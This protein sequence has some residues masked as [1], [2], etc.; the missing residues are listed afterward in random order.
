MVWLEGGPPGKIR[1]SGPLRELWR[2]L[3]RCGLGFAGWLRAGFQP[4]FERDQDV[5]A[6]LDGLR[7]LVIFGLPAQSAS[8]G[9][10]GALEALQLSRSV[11][12]LLESLGSQF[13]PLFS[14]RPPAFVVAGVADEAGS[15][16]QR[17]SLPYAL[18]KQL[19]SRAARH[20]EHRDDLAAAPAD[21]GDGAI[22]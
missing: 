17:L 2:S 5:D 1:A 14:R 18:G 16:Y 13:Q 4:P 15:L 11:V 9:G 22:A 7:V 10:C 6:R 19:F 8:R 21:G 12:D 3:R 20:P